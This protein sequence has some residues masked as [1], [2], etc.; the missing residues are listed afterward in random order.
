MARNAPSQ[1]CQRPEPGAGRNTQPRGFWPTPSLP[2]RLLQTLDTL[3]LLA[4]RH[5]ACQRRTYHHRRRLPVRLHAGDRPPAAPAGLRHAE[6]RT[7]FSRRMAADPE[8][9]P[10]H[11]PT[12]HPGHVRALSRQRAQ[13]YRPPRRPVRAAYPPQGPRACRYGAG[14]RRWTRHPHP[15]HDAHDQVVITFQCSQPVRLA[16]RLVSCSMTLSSLWLS[17]SDLQNRALLL[18]PRSSCSAHTVLGLL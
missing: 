16:P 11:K 12:R 9:R 7:W 1:I 13:V 2:D 3:A 4:H 5:R 8:R 18:P 14:L 17:R 15:P 10:S 6:G